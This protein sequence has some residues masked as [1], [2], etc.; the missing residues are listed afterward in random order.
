M[1]I[2]KF[3]KLGFLGMFLLCINAVTA[4]YA[5]TGGEKTPLLALDNTNYRT[6]IFLVYGMNEVKISYTSQST[7]H[8]WYRYKTKVDDL[9]PEPITSLQNGTTSTVSNIEDGYGYYVDEN[10]A[11]RHYV[12]IMDY[13]KS[14]FDARSINISS[15]TDPCSAIRLEGDVDLPD[16]IYYTPTGLPMKLEREFEVSFETLHWNDTTKIFSA[17]RYVN[18]TVKDPFATSFPP[19]LTDTEIQLKGDK[20][21]AC[22][23]VE[24]TVVTPFYQAKAIAVYADTTI[25]SMGKAGAGSDNE[26]SAPAE[27]Y[28]RAYAN[29]PVAALFN[30]KIFRDEDENPVVNYNSEDFLYT[31]DRV[32]N[33]KVVLEV[34]DRTGTCYSDENQF[35]INISETEMIIPNAFSPGCTPGIND[36]FRVKYQSVIKF[37]GWI[38]NR[39]GNQLFH[40]TDPSQGWNGMYNGKYVPAGAYYY[41]IEYQGTDGKNHVRKGDINVFR[42]KNIDLEEKNKE[43]M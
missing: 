19:P 27:I 3:G 28:F 41:I 1:G 11:M 38:F 34:S 35:E 30:W 10:G 21:A 15:T 16:M 14:A 5:V 25:R 40:W 31:F 8:R 36:I 18:E 26:L 42:G 39:W 12:W 4:Q 13:S 23:G 17:E 7:A 29:I 33:Y 20:F 22:F 43:G 37:Q 9:N 24:K 2:S 32:G 6:K